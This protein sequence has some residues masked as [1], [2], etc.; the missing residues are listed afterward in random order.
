MPLLQLDQC[1]KAMLQK[2]VNQISYGR[3]QDF[4][5]ETET[6]TETFILGLMESRQRLRLSFLVS[7][8]K[9]KIKT[10][11]LS[12]IR[13]TLRRKLL[14]KPHGTKDKVKSTLYFWEHKQ[15]NV[16]KKNKNKRVEK[17]VKNYKVQNL[18]TKLN[19]IFYRHNL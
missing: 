12:I 7:L 13:L 17:Q 3:D 14:F 11:I 19:Y 8:N 9:T 15:I 6:E 2:R 1:D 18:S 5:V 4:E 10:L 16:R